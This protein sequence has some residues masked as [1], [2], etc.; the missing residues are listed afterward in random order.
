VTRSPWIQLAPRIPNALHREFKLH[1]VTNEI[2][3]RNFVVAAIEERLTA[4]R[5]RG[6]AAS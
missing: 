5:K 6:R 2:A 3:A 4:G 1:Y